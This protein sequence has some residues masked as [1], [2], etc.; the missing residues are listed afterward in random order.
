M[1]DFIGKLI[2]KRTPD[3]II[4]DDPQYIKNQEFSQV[5]PVQ[6]EDLVIA[7]AFVA[8]INEILDWRDR[9]EAIDYLANNASKSAGNPSYGTTNEQIINAIIQVGGSGSLVDFE[10]VKNCVTIVFDMY[11]VMALSA[12]TGTNHA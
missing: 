12:L 7:G 1:L 5:V 11:D 8:H 3:D 10:L 6:N 4:P 9:I 2:F